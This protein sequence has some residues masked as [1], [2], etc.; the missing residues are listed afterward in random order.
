MHLPVVGQVAINQPQPDAAAGSDDQG[1]L[2]RRV[3]PAASVS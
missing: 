2:H 3:K 1:S